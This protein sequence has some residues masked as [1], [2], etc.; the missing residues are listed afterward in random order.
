M[1]IPDTIKAQLPPWNSLEGI[2]DSRKMCQVK[3]MSLDGSRTLYLLEALYCEES[4]WTYLC[5]NRRRYQ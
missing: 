4:G 3:L 1:K 5:V 2:E